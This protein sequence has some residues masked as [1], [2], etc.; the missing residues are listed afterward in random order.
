MAVK[1]QWHPATGKRTVYSV[2]LE[3]WGGI[4]L[5]FAASACA[6]LWLALPPVLGAVLARWRRAFAEADASALNARRREALDL[7]TS[8][9]RQ[10]S[11]RLDTDRALVGRIA[12]LYGLRSV[13]RRVAGAAGTAAAEP[14]SALETSERRVAVLAQAVSAIETEEGKDAALA[15]FT[16]STAPFPETAWVAT[17]DFGWRVSRIT[18]R[19]EFAAGLDLAAPRGRPVFA[20]AD[21]TVRW[22]GPVT[23][24]G[25]PEYFRFGKI[26]AIRHGGRAVTVYGNLE[27]VSVRRGQAL[28][29]GDR[30]GTVGVSPWF[31]APRLRYE[32]WRTFEG[33]PYPIDPR[34]AILTDR[35]PEV[36]DALRK[37]LASPVRPPFP[38]PADFR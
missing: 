27:S 14:A 11:E 10:A 4:V 24:R 36:L 8:A 17:G 15:P 12:Y 23:F 28:R 32:V 37:A 13:A 38:L 16:P 20:S 18:N 35:S 34:L 9:L 26:V 3:A 25:A 19:T 33:E 1:V 29:R 6:L 31:G 7:A 30:I 22:T 2:D 5:F 21:G